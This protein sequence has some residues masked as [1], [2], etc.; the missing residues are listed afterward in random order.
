M[1]IKYKCRC[2]NREIE[3]VVT[4]RV[5]GSDIADWMGSVVEMSVSYHHRSKSPSCTFDKL[6]YLKIP[7]PDEGDGLGVPRVKN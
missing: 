5:K 4:D 3:I 6:E 2:M 7:A 1:N